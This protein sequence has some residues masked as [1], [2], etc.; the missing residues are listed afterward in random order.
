[1]YTDQVCRNPWSIY[2][3]SWLVP[4]NQLSLLCLW[5]SSRNRR[6]RQDGKK[7]RIRRRWVTKLRCMACRYRGEAG[8]HVMKERFVV[9]QQR[10]ESPSTMFSR[11]YGVQW[12]RRTRKKESHCLWNLEK[13]YRSQEE[14]EKPTTTIFLFRIPFFVPIFCSEVPETMALSPS[15]FL[16]WVCGCTSFFIVRPEFDRFRYSNCMGVLFLCVWCARMRQME[17]N[18]WLV[19][20]SSTV[21]EGLFS[22][23][24]CLCRGWV[25][26]ERPWRCQW[27]EMRRDEMSGVCMYTGLRS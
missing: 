16:S 2:V 17:W 15:P 13:Q 21:I 11:I 9:L 27:Q 25:V 22:A 10:H 23:I 20:W 4:R 26:L 24:I 12:E 8:Q 6:V 18:G 19:R 7:S 14:K 3:H 1:M 5:E